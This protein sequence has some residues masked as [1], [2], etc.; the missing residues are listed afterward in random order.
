MSRARGRGSE[1][2]PSGDAIRLAGVAKRLGTKVVL[3][4]L[5]LSVPVGKTYAI[6]GR[7][8]AG[9]S[10]TLKHVVGLIV[11]DK[12]TVSVLG[13]DVARLGRAD[14]ARHR[15]RIGYLFQDGALLAWM[16]VA[17]NVALPL[18]E[19]ERLGRKEVARR[20]AEKLARVGLADAGG[21]YPSELSG[22]MRK[23]AGLARA[24]I[25]EPE[26]VLYDEPTSG[27]DPVMSSQINELIVDVRDSLGVTSVVVTHDMTSAYR[28][29][30]RIGM[31]YEGKLVGEGT[32]DEIRSTDH[33]V[34][35][36]FIEGRIDGPIR[37]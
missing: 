11:P 34:I 25:R 29:A 14:L 20:V 21:K 2:E 22:G 35:R 7:S 1:S 23:R 37:A 27:L 5:S 26:L 13:S 28:I 18:F 17:Q 33:P 10:V 30:D 9:K 24:L 4:G 12:G 15:K 19:H 32:P 36:Q 8:G 31:L 3:D 16:T 6:I